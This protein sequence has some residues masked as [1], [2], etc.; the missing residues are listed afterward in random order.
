MRTYIA[1]V[2]VEH[3]ITP[4]PENYSSFSELIILG[5]FDLPEQ[6]D[7]SQ[8]IIENQEDLLT[9]LLFDISKVFN[10]A[11]ENANG[12]M[13]SLKVR[14]IA[15]IEDFNLPLESLSENTEIDERLYTYE[16]AMSFNDIKKIYY[17]GM[18]SD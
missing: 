5:H 18:F 3:I 8:L 7:F 6:L 10:D 2:L 1:R 14:E 12:E 17:H 9:Q 15:K 16:K 13:I 11:Y 4:C